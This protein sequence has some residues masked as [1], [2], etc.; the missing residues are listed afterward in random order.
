MKTKVLIITITL[1]YL[2]AGCQLGGAET[3]KPPSPA[4]PQISVEADASL[5]KDAYLPGEDIVIEFSF[6]NV[7]TETFELAPFPPQIEI[8]RPSPYDE[9]VRSFPAGAESKSLAPD[10]VVSYTLT[11]DQRNDQGQQVA[12][13]HYYLK[14]LFVSRY[15]QLLI[16]P[17]EGVIERTIEVNESLTVNDIT[18]TLERV[19]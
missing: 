6:K 2:F 17:A 5:D 14:L 19:N 18:F 7:T 8:M 12:Y 9:P 4:P 3:R 1:S 10:E 13:G 11:W 16:L 15:L